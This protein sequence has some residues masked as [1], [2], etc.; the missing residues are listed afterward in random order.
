MIIDL[1]LDRKQNEESFDPVMFA[2][3]VHDYSDVFPHYVEMILGPKD[4]AG[5]KAGLCAYVRAEGYPEDICKYINSVNWAPAWW[6][7]E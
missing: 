2:F 4:E 6:D 5:R 3:D 7:A 1:I